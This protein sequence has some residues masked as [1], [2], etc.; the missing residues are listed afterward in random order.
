MW[1]CPAA[2]FTYRTAHAPM[3]DFNSRRIVSILFIAAIA[4]VFTLSFGPGS[5]GCE[6]PT[7]ST[8]PNAVATVNGKE[9]PVVEF[10]RSYRNMLNMYRQQGLSEQL[11][12]QLGLHKQV[13]DQLVNTE[14]L[15]QAAEGHGISPSDEELA[16]LLHESPDFQKNGQFDP[17]QY[18]DVLRQYYRKTDLE[19]EKDLRR[20]LAAS[21]LLETVAESATV[22]ED[23]VRARFLKEGNRAEATF[24]RFVPTMFAE[25]VPAPTADELA[26]FKEEK[27]D[28]ISAQYEQNK[29]LYHQPEQVRARHI[30]IKTA[31]EPTEAELNAAKDKV[32]NLKKQLT[33]E[34][35]DFAELAKQFSEDQGSK[36]QGGDLGFNTAD[37]WVKP[38]S[39]AAFS[40]QPGQISDPVVS[41]FGVHLIKVEEK[42][43]PQSKELAEVSDEIA[44]QLWKREKAKDVAKQ[45]AE[46]ALAK[47]RAGRSLTELFPPSAEGE[48]QFNF[49][50]PTAPEAVATGEFNAATEAIP[51]L[52]VAPQIVP[53]VFKQDAAGALDRVYEVGDAFVLVQVTAR[54]KPADAD[55]ESQRDTL[56]ADARRAKQMELRDSFLRALREKGEVV[57][58]EQAIDEVLG[59]LGE[60]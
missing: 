25:Q 15:A 3:T 8:A 19:F 52:G 1:D 7:G 49:N 36:V 54:H 26:K 58:N 39:D 11:A 51:K 56:F 22:S 31:E 40:L 55:F 30:L 13:L 20:Q 59:P 60:S 27:K 18:R 21:R 35:A 43:P 41:R 50:Q 44:G 2:R 4:V 38:F 28:A 12:R 34:N 10:R 47:V 53:D 24:A 46:E 6:A 48:P 14:L 9:I 17:Q 33:E 37:G 5:R 45:R 57:T 42:R 29:F 23:E 32:A 16:K